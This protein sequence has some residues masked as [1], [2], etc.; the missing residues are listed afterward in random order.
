[1]E[2]RLEAP[3]VAGDFSPY[4][5]PV[6]GLR[7]SGR[8]EHAANL[9]RHGARVLEPGESREVMRKRAFET[10]DLERRIGDTVDS[11]IASMPLAKREKLASEMEAG[12]TAV[13]TRAT[14]KAP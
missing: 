11:A 12:V 1:M 7:I 3:A 9:R 4:N 13:P 5:C 6:S 10:A 8:K 2:R 14:G